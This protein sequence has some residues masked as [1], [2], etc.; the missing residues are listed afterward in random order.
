M[1]EVR[2]IIGG[3][4]GGLCD[5]FEEAALRLLWAARRGDGY[6]LLGETQEFVEGGP[7]EIT[8]IGVVIGGTLVF[9]R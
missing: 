5:L 3:C 4:N 8:P 9:P 6:E 2:E 1:R 7:D